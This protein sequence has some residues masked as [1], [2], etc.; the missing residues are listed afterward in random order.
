M[1]DEI[2]NVSFPSI[3]KFHKSSFSLHITHYINFRQYD[4]IILLSLLSAG[5][6]MNY[7]ISVNTIPFNQTRMYVYSLL[8]ISRLYDTDTF[9]P[10]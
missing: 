1:E 10:T 4:T 9:T 5:N 8:C 3:S 2:K 6:K 7:F